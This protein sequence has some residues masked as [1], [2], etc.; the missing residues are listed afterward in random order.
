MAKKG[1]SIARSNYEE[2]K[3][4]AFLSSAT[5]LQYL[6]NFSMLLRYS[7]FSIL[8]HFFIFLKLPMDK[9]GV[10]FLHMLHKYGFIIM[11]SLLCSLN[12]AGFSG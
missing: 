6:G 10:F 7:R 3:V 5:I 11:N 4:G 1:L 8:F 12:N 9:N 2:L